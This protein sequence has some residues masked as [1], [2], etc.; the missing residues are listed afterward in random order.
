MPA[1]PSQFAQAGGHDIT[2]P[3]RVLSTPVAFFIFR[4]P[5]CTRQVFDAIRAARPATL[6]VTADG[7]RNEE[8]RKL[9]L[10]AR[11]VTE[12][13][14]WDCSVTRQY[15]NVNLGCGHRM[16]SG[17]NAVFDRHDRAIILEDDC[18][19][20]AGFFGYCAELLER[21]STNT[22]IS[23]ISGT[24]VY[25]YQRAQGRSY[26]F[27]RYSWIWGWATWSRAWQSYDFHVRDWPSLRDTNWLY[28][29]LKDR[30]ACLFWRGILDR[31][32]RG[33]IDTWDYQWTFNCLRQDGLSVVPSVNMVSNIGFGPDATHTTDGKHRDGFRKSQDYCGSL[34]HPLEIE[35]NA[36]L[37]AR[38]LRS[39]LYFGFEAPSPLELLEYNLLQLRGRIPKPL[40]RVLRSISRALALQ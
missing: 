17:L 31:V 10:A 24:S 7:W 25:P 28:A 22:R 19:P 3:H 37:D 12:E 36:S 34:V 38:A 6:I 29:A 5:E 40:R 2:T 1:V 23:A 13:I 27:S 9:C 16:A 20:T 32:S 14:D 35:W 8:E 30:S 33:E 4:R 15:S 18:L 39:T 21:Y 26:A 11:A